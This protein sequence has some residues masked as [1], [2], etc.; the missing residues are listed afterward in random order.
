MRHVETMRGDGTVTSSDGEQM[1]VHYD[2][3]VFQKE[4]PVGGG[5][6]IPGMKSIH[7]RV[8]PVCFFGDGNL[9]L[10]MEDGKKMTFFFTD[11][12]GSIAFRGWTG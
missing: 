11:T 8:S 4:I 9:M 5:E 10:K 2:I 12:N 6:T 1:P 3:E 7:G